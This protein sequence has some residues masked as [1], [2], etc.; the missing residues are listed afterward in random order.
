[1]RRNTL[2]RPGGNSSVGGLVPALW[3]AIGTPARNPVCSHQ[4][5]MSKPAPPT[6]GVLANVFLPS[7]AYSRSIKSANQKEKKKIEA[8]TTVSCTLAIC[9]MGSLP[10]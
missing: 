4:Q 2:A 6:F 1:M 7:Q 5:M 3:F 8:S 9:R 10:A